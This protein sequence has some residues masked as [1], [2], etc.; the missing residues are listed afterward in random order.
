[1]ND[2]YF[3][4]RDIKYTKWKLPR[5]SLFF[6]KIFLLNTDR[7]YRGLKKLDCISLHVLL[8]TFPINI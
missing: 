2:T 7:I 5:N 4:N 8:K 3:I 1:M 6:F